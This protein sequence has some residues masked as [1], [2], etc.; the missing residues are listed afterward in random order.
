LNAQLKE[1]GDA[2]VSR[3][4][5]RSDVMN[6]LGALGIPSEMVNQSLAAWDIERN[7]R[8]R[9]LSE[10][11]YRKALGNDLINVAEYMENLRGIGYT[12][13]DL[14]LLA[15]MA[16]SPDEAGPV[17]LSGPMPLAEREV[18]A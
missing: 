12:E 10:A 9:R 7:T 6:Q 18:K 5:N 14:W 8:S 2:Y 1:T 16:T 15:A 11:Q 4:I 3:G 17:P 13:Y